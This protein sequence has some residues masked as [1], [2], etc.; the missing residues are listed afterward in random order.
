MPRA[1]ST[2]PGQWLQSLRRWLGRAL[3]AAPPELPVALWRTTLALHP[4]LHEL[5]PAEQNR[6]RELCQRFLADKEFHG[7]HGLCISDEVALTIA[8]QACL[9][10]LHMAPTAAKA[11]AWYDDFVGIVV[12]PGQVVAQRENP[13]E[14]G[15]VHRYQEVLAGEAMP[16]GPIMLSWSDVQATRSDSAYSVVIHEFAH[17]LDL[18]DGEADGCPPLPPGFMGQTSPRAA[19]Q[20]WLTTFGHAYAEFREQVIQAERFGTPSPWLD[21]YGATSGVEFFAVCSEA[22]FLN[23]ARFTSEFPT[24]MPLLDGF[25]RQAMPAD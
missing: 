24:L 11:L 16:D 8:A 6:L 19:R 5:H 22:Y 1:P 18:R 23:R 13:D 17:K 4:F 9:P 3:P 10:L 2:L 12:H 21:S 7:T 15:V 25:Y 14:L 20:H